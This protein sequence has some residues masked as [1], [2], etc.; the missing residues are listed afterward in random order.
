MSHKMQYKLNNNAKIF[1]SHSYKGFSDTKYKRNS[2]LSH[3]KPFINNNATAKNKSSLENKPERPCHLCLYF[4]RRKYFKTF[5][6]WL[7]FILS[8]KL[9]SFSRYSIFS[10]F[11]SLI[12][13]FKGSDGT[14]W[15][16]LHKLA[17]VI[18]GI[19]QKPFCIK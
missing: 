18:F 13:K 7:L 3:Y 16:G 4:T 17:N 19:T 1:V 15:T 2:I 11:F 10:I 9:F 8:K 14:S 5:G 12:S 6:K